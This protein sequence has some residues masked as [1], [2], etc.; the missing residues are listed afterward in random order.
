LHVEICPDEHYY[1]PL[2]TKAAEEMVARVIRLL[3]GRK[4]KKADLKWVDKKLDD[5]AAKLGKEI[6]GF[7]R[8]QFCE[9]RRKLIAGVLTQCLFFV[10]GRPGSGKTRALREVVARLRENGEA[11]TILAPT[12]KATLRVKSEAPDDVEV[13]TIDRWINRSGLR[14]YADSIAMLPKMETSAAYKPVQNLIIDESSMVDLTRL[15]VVLRAL[16]VHEPNVR[17][18]VFVGDENQLPPIGMG[19]PLYDI[20]AFLNSD[21][22]TADENIVRLR[23]NCRQRQDRTVIDA[24]Y[25]FAGKNRYSTDLYQKLLKGG[26]ILTEGQKKSS[27]RVEYWETPEALNQLIT[28]HLD[29]LLR[30]E[31]HLTGGSASS[32]KPPR[33]MIRRTPAFFAA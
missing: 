12:G 24:A 17:R 4:P 28:H 15:A 23:T 6:P 27:L 29:E 30:R 21:P 5:E 32:P 19:R 9:E 1:Y 2:E 13:E 31:E 20:L 22:K 7:T 25:L 3:L 33:Y 26:E 16:E 10:T 8:E 11:V 18:V 14:D